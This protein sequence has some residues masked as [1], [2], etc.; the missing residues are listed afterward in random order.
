V[1]VKLTS[2]CQKLGRQPK[3]RRKIHKEVK[4]RI[5]EYFEAAMLEERLGGFL[6]CLLC[7]K[8]RPLEVTCRDT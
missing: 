1:P 7:L 2:G 6:R 3:G 4:H 5:A 8:A